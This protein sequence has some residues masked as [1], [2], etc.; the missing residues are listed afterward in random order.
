[1]KIIWRLLQK[2]TFFPASVFE[3]LLGYSKPYRWYFVGAILAALLVSGSSV[4]ALTLVERGTAAFMS[5]QIDDLG[6]VLLITA[7]FFSIIGGIAF[8]QVY[9]SAYVGQRI[10]TDMR[11]ISLQH[12]LGLSMAFQNRQR[13]GDLMSRIHQD[14]QIIQHGMGKLVTRLI[15]SIFMPPMVIAYLFYLNW[16]LTLLSVFLVPAFV[17]ILGHLGKKLRS[18]GHQ[19]AV[20]MANLNVR[21]QEILANLYII[22]CFGTESHEAKRFERKNET[23]FQASM[24]QTTLLALERPIVA[25][26]QMFSFLAIIWYGGWLLADGEISQQQAMA[27][28]VGLGI[29]VESISSLSKLHMEL[30]QLF[31]SVERFTQLLSNKNSVVELPNAVPLKTVDRNIQLKGV[32]FRYEEK[33]Y[34]ALNNIDLTIQA[35]Q[36]VAL[37]GPSG[38][39]KT[40]LVN[41]MLRLYD[42]TEG[43]VL[44]DDQNLRMTSLSSLRKLIG[45]VPQ[46]LD[47]FSGTI[48]ENIAYGMMQVSEEKI[49]KA[50]SMANADGFISRLPDGY[51]TQV[52][53]RGLQLS[54]GERQ[55]IAIARVFLRDPSI[56]ILDEATAYQD[57]ESEH[58]IQQSLQRLLRNR[59]A[60]IIAHRLS[61]VQ[62]ANRII[63]LDQGQIKE[64]GSHQELIDRSGLYQRLYEKQFV[65]A[66]PGETIESSGKGNEQAVAT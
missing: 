12:I 36:Q 60:I 9:L 48:N 50:A 55:R 19:T 26:F 7:I 62:K 33:N 17:V 32:C 3:I 61:T 31:V 39:G 23:Y 52:G 13:T 30:Q 38:A 15:R 28:F 22:K 29:L 8:I 18:S 10:A 24:W 56:L 65:D 64:T 11:Q 20:E 49:H 43:E 47:L 1:M 42:P 59:T 2:Q 44:V 14:I 57:T 40:T 4:V 58:L 16:K 51:Q 54:A 27:F 66:V 6:N 46:N 5:S 25:L 45:I 53:E 35:G 63:V 37:V 21:L 34:D 41:L